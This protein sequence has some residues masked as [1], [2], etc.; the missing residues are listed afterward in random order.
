[1]LRLTAARRADQDI[2]MW[3]FKEVILFI[4]YKSHDK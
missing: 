2:F 3:S 4:N 1:M